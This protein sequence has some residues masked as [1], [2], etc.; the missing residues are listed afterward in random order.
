M[1]DSTTNLDS[2]VQGSGSQDLQANALYDAAS[3]AMLYGRRASTTT[4]TTWG[5]YGGPM[6]V[7]GALT[8]K[9]NWLADEVGRR[10]YTQPRSSV[11]HP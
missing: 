6:V 1:A 9:A 7:D 8:G 11:W 10:E 5:Y 2:I 3:Q 4:G